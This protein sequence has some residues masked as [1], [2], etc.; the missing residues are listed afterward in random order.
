ML[1]QAL[2]SILGQER[3]SEEAELV[4]GVGAAHDGCAVVEGMAAAEAGVP[5]RL[6]HSRVV[7]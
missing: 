1:D 2:L 7:C 3:T 6:R 5:G 4:C